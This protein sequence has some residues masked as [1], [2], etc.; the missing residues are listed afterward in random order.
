MI[1]NIDRQMYWIWIEFDFWRTLFILEWQWNFDVFLCEWHRIRIYNI[2]RKK[3]KEFDSSIEKHLRH[4]KFRF[5]ELLS[6]R[7]NFAQIRHD[8]IDTELLY[9]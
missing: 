5:I 4:A 8:L 1:A 2:A 7:A 6:R 9:E 3:R